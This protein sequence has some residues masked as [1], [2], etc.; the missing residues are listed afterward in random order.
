MDTKPDHFIRCAVTDD[1]PLALNLLAGY[2]EKTPFLRLT[3]TYTNAIDTLSAIRN[4]NSKETEQCIDLLF[5]D[6]QMPELSGLELS[7]IIK[8]Q[9]NSDKKN[10][11]GTKIIFTTAF[12]QYAIDGYKVEAIDYLLK[13]ISYSEFLQ[14][15]TKARSIILQ[16][17]AFSAATA[18]NNQNRAEVLYIKSEYKYIQVQ[19]RDIIYIEGLKD[20]IK[21]YTKT[22]TTPLLTLM[23]MKSA[24]EKLVPFSFMRVHR[25]YIVN[26]PE[27]KIIEK[28]RIILKNEKVLPIGESYRNNIFELIK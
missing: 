5:L 19:I 3:G 27:I 16:E 6:I 12:E 17:Q 8:E 20:Y 22:N 21:I 14:A 24:E 7:R 10:S 13:P 11:L 28:G 4:H 23:S 1:E 9:N 2:I 25:S 26:I 18:G 15:A